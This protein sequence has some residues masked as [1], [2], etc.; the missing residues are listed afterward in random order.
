MINFIIAA[1]EIAV[2]WLK[3][4]TKNTIQEIHFD[5]SF[6]YTL[7][8]SLG[9]LLAILPDVRLTELRT[10]TSLCIPSRMFLIVYNSCPDRRMINGP[11][12]RTQCGF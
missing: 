4:S 12:F 1:Y 7:L 2:N 9:L 8:V 11:V 10:P 3:T 5:Y 6:T